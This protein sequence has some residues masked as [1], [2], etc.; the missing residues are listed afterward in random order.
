MMDPKGPI[1]WYQGLFLQPQHFQQCDI[2]TESLLAPLKNYIQPFFW[3]V[4]AMEIDEGALKDMVFDLKSGEFIFQD[5]TWVGINKNGKVRSRSFRELWSQSKDPF[6]VYVGLKRWNF[7]GGNLRVDS[8][9]GSGLFNSRF[10]VKD[11]PSETPDLYQEEHKASVET[12]DYAINF[13]W[14]N[15]IERYSEYHLMPIAR[16]E[17]NGQDPFIAQDFVPPAVTVSSSPVLLRYFKNIKDILFSRCLVLSEYKNPKG[18]LASDFQASY[19]NFLLA[20]R[21]IN[22]Y[23]SIINHLCTASHIHPWTLYGVLT[24]FIGELSSYTDRIDAIGRTETGEE[25]LPAYDHNNLGYCFKQAYLLIDEILD[26]LLRGME[27]IVHLIKDG[28]YFK[29]LVPVNLLSSSNAF[30][31][32]FKMQEDGRTLLDT[33]KHILKISSQE[34]MP[35][36]IRRSLPGLPLEYV[37]EPPPGLPRRANVVYFRIEHT[38]KYWE[39]IRNNANICVFWAGAPE[40]VSIELVILKQ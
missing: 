28:D 30:Y 27:S 36:L 4:S 33:A 9:S 37:P 21:T 11:V 23:I 40:D 16:I 20:S 32:G 34:D 38:S 19:F 2:Y 3:G 35:T 17:F 15:E 14:D 29:A 6:I 8:G 22:R 39:N 12:L 31:L 5:G 18:F 13:I 10:I 24:Q 7:N 1:F 26:Y 25:L